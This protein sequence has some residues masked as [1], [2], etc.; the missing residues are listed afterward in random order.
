MI[1]SAAQRIPQDNII[2]T[3]TS[4]TSTANPVT[5]SWPIS[6]SKEPEASTRFPLR[7]RPHLTKSS[8]LED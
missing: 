2:L 4:T 7:W 6:A 8:R 3:S 5:F 1:G